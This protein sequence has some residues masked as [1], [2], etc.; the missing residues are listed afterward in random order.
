M[1]TV[2][3]TRWGPHHGP[4]SAMLL[5]VGG[6]GNVD[7]SPAAHGKVVQDTCVTCHLYED[8]H[9]FDPNVAACKQCHSDAENFDIGG[10]Q[11]EVA[12]MLD[13]LKTALAANGMIVSVDD[14]T[15]V[16]GDYPEAEAAALWNYIFIAHEDKSMGVHNPAYTIA[17]LQA[18]IDALK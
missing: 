5:G 15:P 7:G 12:G 11:T 16:V 17:L 13:E 3:S 9:S 10:V 14:D 8:N 2:D 6:A 18:S 4:Q 1:V